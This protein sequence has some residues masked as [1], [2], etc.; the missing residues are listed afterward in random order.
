MRNNEI[1]SV[2]APANR[3]DCFQ[4]GAGAGRQGEG[5]QEEPGGLRQLRMQGA[6]GARVYMMECR[7]GKSS[8]RRM[9]DTCRGSPSNIRSVFI[10]QNTHVKK[11][12]EA[13]EDLSRWIRGHIPSLCRFTNS[14]NSGRF[15]FL[16]LQKSLLMVTA[17]TKLEDSGSLEGKL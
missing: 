5:T 13:E 2:I 10:A 8:R 6:K 7:R 3:L 15:C 17:A 16:G 1:S 14:G 9:P 12:P 4:T 11:F